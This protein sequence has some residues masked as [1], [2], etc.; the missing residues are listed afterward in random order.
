MADYVSSYVAPDQA[1]RVAISAALAE[2]YPTAYNGFTSDGKTTTYH[3]TGDVVPADLADA[4]APLTASVS[5]KALA[6]L[7]STLAAD[8]GLDETTRQAL[9]GMAA[10]LAPQSPT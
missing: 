2:K 3:F 5:S 6:T 7:L 8:P 10:T 1:T 9:G 4:L